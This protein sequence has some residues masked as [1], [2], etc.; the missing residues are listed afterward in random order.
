LVTYHFINILTFADLISPE[1]WF[2]GIL[3]VLLVGVAL[4]VL[5]RAYVKREKRKKED[6]ERTVE[7][8]TA[9]ISEKNKEIL[10]QK[11]EIERQQNKISEFYNE[12][13]QSILTAQRIQTSFLPPISSIKKYLPNFFEIYIPK[14]IVSGDFYWMHVKYDKIYLAA[15]D[16]TGHGV[17]GA[18]MSIIG[19]NLLKQIVIENATYNAAEILSQLSIELVNT[20]HQSDVNTITSDGMDI[21]LCILDTDKGI[22]HFAGANNPLYIVNANGELRQLPG[23]KMGIGIQKGKPTSGFT[24]HI[25]EMSPTDRYFLFSDGFASQFGGENGNEKLKY[26]RFREMIIETSKLPMEDQKEQ[27]LLRL[28]AWKG[29]TEQT[30]DIMLLAFE[31]PQLSEDY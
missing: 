21:S 13:K 28:Q 8:R 31:A 1:S 9:E 15:I 10:S 3:D 29:E 24:N 25:I 5:F 23:D 7:L 20:L 26:S 6:L 27:L 4:F 30:D 12:L 11:E 18:F 16:C 17:A 14:D 19:N 2:N 22:I